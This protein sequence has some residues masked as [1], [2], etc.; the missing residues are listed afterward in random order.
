[1][2]PFLFSPMIASIHASQTLPLTRIDAPPSIY[3]NS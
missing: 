1:L 3:L 2:F